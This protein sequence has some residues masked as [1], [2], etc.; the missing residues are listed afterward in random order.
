[1][2]HFFSLP[3]NNSKH[4]TFIMTSV[5]NQVKC[6]KEYLNEKFRLK[7][8]VCKRKKKWDNSSTNIMMIKLTFALKSDFGLKH[9]IFTMKISNNTPLYT[10]VFL[11]RIHMFHFI[12]YF[13]F[14][15]SK[16]SQTIKSSVC[17]AQS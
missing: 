13:I 7:P 15:G 12:Q 11:F 14:F 10:V 6:N 16:F 4:M 1:M 5:T 3:S 17:F 9:L 8:H 2:L